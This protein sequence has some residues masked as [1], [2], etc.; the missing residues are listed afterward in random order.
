VDLHPAVVDVA[1]VRPD[2]L[3]ALAHGRGDQVRAGA[4]AHVFAAGRARQGLTGNTARLVGG[5]DLAEQVAI[6]LPNVDH[7]DQVSK[8]RV[9]PHQNVQIAVFLAIDS[10][11]DATK[12]GAGLLYDQP[13]R[14]PDVRQG[15]AGAT[16]EG[17]R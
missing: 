13:I 15:L 16:T 5:N 2:E 7:V 1:H 6:Q 8:L 10:G 4:D 14:A 17:T 12:D 9:H 11:D 3:D